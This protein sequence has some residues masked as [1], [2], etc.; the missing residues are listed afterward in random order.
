MVETEGTSLAKKKISEMAI[1]CGFGPNVRVETM[2]SRERI[3]SYFAKLAL[4][5]TGAS[6]KNQIPLNAPPHFRRIRATQGLLPKR[7]K[8]D[9]ITGVMSMFPAEVI[10]AE[11][12]KKQTEIL[13]CRKSQINQEST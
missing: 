6:E 8:D 9:T 5:L 4:E 12:T 3:S 1:P 11:L 2:R 7:V 13:R 10:H